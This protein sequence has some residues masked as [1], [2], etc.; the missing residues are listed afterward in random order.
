MNQ[1]DPEINIFLT[2]SQKSGGQESVKKTGRKSSFPHTKEMPPG[3][4]LSIL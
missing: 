1:V 4:G 3:I 2:T